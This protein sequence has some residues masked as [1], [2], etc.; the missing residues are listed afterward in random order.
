MTPYTTTSGKKS[1]VSEYEIGD[2]YIIVQFYSAQY[3]YSY[4]SCGKTATEAMKRLASASSGLSTFIAQ[5][6]PAYEWK[7]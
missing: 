7:R 4:S 6:K 3:K 1:G 2:N 5:N